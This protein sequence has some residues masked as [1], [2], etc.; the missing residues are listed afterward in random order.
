[1]LGK[2]RTE[3]D[4]GAANRDF[5]QV[6]V[7]EGVG[8]I[9]DFGAFAVGEVGMHYDVRRGTSVMA[10]CLFGMSILIMRWRIEDGI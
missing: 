3:R 6:Q 2:M 5:L 10:P 1:M 8:R 4:W 7:W 9:V